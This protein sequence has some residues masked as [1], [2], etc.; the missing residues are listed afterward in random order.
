MV[1]VKSMGRAGKADAAAESLALLRSA[2]ITFFGMMRVRV[3]RISATNARAPLLLRERRV[4][5]RASCEC[6]WQQ[7][8]GRLRWSWNRIAVV[9]H[10]EIN[11]L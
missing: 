4:S 10:T 3:Q 6:Q 11:Y 2:V 5:S 8:N 7:R 9:F 1:D